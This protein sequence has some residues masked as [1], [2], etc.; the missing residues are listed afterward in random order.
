MLENQDQ[1]K[2]CQAS[3]SDSENKRKYLRIPIIVTKVKAE[4]N[5][6]IFFGYA[7]NI[8]KGGFFIQTVSPK[9]KGEQFTVEF[10]LPENLL[11]I[12]CLVEVVWKRNYIPG[13][14]HPGMGLKFIDL[15]EDL[16]EK[17]ED[18]CLNR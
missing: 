4:Q 1:E 11:R 15:P 8:S 7:T 18:W 13:K 9:D 3:D 5:G 17:I 16:A 12:R 14:N 6:N 2:G 10:E